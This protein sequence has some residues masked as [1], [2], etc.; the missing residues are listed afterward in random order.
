MIRSRRLRQQCAERDGKICQLCG[1]FDAKGEA[2]HIQEL[3]E[4]GPDALENLRWLCRHCHKEKTISR[5]PIRAK[6]DRL[7]ERSDLTRKRRAIIREKE[8]T[9]S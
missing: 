3:W 1:R 8:E 2:D 4:K 7:R 9:G 5:I 6:T